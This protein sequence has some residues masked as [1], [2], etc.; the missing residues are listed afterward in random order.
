M[1]GRISWCSAR[2]AAAALLDTRPKGVDSRKSK[3]KFTDIDNALKNCRKPSPGQG[4]DT[5]EIE[6]KVDVFRGAL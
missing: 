4:I 3:E 2:N 1:P 5:A 6:R